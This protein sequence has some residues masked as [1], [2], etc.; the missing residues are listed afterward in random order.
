MEFY[1]VQKYCDCC[2]WQFCSDCGRFNELFGNLSINYRIEIKLIFKLDSRF[3][4]NC[5][6][7]SNSSAVVQ[8]LIKKKKKNKDKTTEESTRFDKLCISCVPSLEAI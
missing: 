4:C 2:F 8:M 3:N 6:R 7:C 5:L 1:A